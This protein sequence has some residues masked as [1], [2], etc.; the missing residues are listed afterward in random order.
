MVSRV[1]YLTHPEVEI[2][3]NVPV[4]DVDLERGWPQASARVSGAPDG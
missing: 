1:R 3:P 4:P 2:D